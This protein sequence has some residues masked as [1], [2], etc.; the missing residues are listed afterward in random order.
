MSGFFFSRRSITRFVTASIMIGWMLPGGLRNCPAETTLKQQAGDGE[1]A[2]I[3]END[4]LRLTITPASGGRGASLIDK[5]TGKEL[6]RS[7]TSSQAPGGSGL[8][9]D[10]FW[11][12]EQIR[13]FEEMPYEATVKENSPSVVS[14]TLTRICRNLKVEKTVTLQ[15]GCRSIQVDY[16]ITNEGDQDYTGRFWVVNSVSPAAASRELFF[17]YPYGEFVSGGTDKKQ[18]T[19]ITYNPAEN[20]ATAAEKSNVYVID[21]AR[22]WGAVASEDKIGAVFQIEYPYFERFYSY[23]PPSGGGEAIPTFEW[24]YT[25]M[26]LP[27][28]AK[29]KAEAILHPEAL[30]PL[31]GYI[32]RTGWRLIPFAGLP[33]VDGVAEG[34][35]GSLIV[36]REGVKV[37][38]AGDRNRELQV[39]VSRYVSPT[40]KPEEQL[41]SRKMDL[42]PG[43][44]E[45]FTLPATLREKGTCV[46]RVTLKER[47]DGREIAFF[48]TPSVNET[49][50]FPYVMAPRETKDRLFSPPE[51][52]AVSFGTEGLDPCIEWA[53]PL[54]KPVKALVIFPAPAHREVAELARR[55]DIDL[56]AVAV[57]LPHVP[58]YDPWTAWWNS[59]PF[60]ILERSLAK[61]YDVIVIAGSL[62]WNTLP[63]NSRNT[64]LQKVKEGAGLIY[65]NPYVFNGTELE[66]LLKTP[67][68]KPDTDFLTSGV[69]SSAIPGLKEF[70]PFS[71]VCDTYPCGKGRIVRINYNVFPNG[72]VY[73]AIRC[74][75]P[76]VNDDSGYYFPYWEYYY[77]FVTKAILFAAQKEPKVLFA[78]ME[79]QRNQKRL[80]IKINNSGRKENVE[81]FLTVYN[82]LWEKLEERT[83]RL[84]LAP[85]LNET[86]L[87]VDPAKFRLAGDH[88][89]NVIVKKEG[90][91]ENWAT[92]CVN[93]T[94]PVR[95]AE[96]TMVKT[97]Y[98]K[99]DPILARIAVEHDGATE[100][101]RYSLHY[102]ISDV[103]RRVLVDK[104]KEF[105]A[106]EKTGGKTTVALEEK[107]DV[108]ALSTLCSLDVEL[109]DGKRIVDYARTHFTV[110]M[111]VEKDIIFT[112]WGPG[113]ANHWTQRVTLQHL[114]ELGFQ[115]ATGPN[116]N[117][118]A[119]EIPAIARGYLAAGLD[120][121]PMDLHRFG[122]GDL[123]GVVRTPC[124]TDPVYLEKM[125]H[126]VERGTREYGEYFPPAFFVG[127]ENSLGS[128]S[129]PHDFCQSPT[130]LEKFR[131]YLKGKY[132]S[133]EKLNGIWNTS[134][135][136]WDKVLPYTLAEAKEKNNFVP[137][138]E[139]RL[140]IFGVFAGAFENEKRFL[141][142]TDP[143]GR[144]AASGMGIPDVNNGFDWYLLSQQLDYIVSYGGPGVPEML[145]S[146]KRPGSFLGSWQGYR[147]SGDGIQSAVWQE[148]FM[149]FLNPGYWWQGLL[150]N[151]GDD[152]PSQFGRDYRK[153]I[154]E[155]KE[156]GIGKILVEA[157]WIPS[158]VA[159]LQSTP[160]LIA[161][162]VTGNSS[163]LQQGV[164]Q[165]NLGGWSDLV[166][167]LGFPP[168]DFLSGDQIKAGRLSPGKYPLFALPLSQALSNEEMDAI[169]SYVKQGGILIADSRPG[170]FLE[171]CCPRKTNPLDEVFGISSASQRIDQTDV[172]ISFS[173]D[174]G[175][176]VRLPVTPVET[177]LELK[178]GRA[179][180][181]AAVKRQTKTVNFGGLAVQ[182]KSDNAASTPAFIL[183]KYGKGY[184]LLLNCEF[185]NYS[186]LS[187]QGLNNRV[188]VEAMKAMLQKAGFESEVKADLP[189]GS[190][191]SRYRDGENEYYGLSRGLD[192]SRENN[193][194]RITLPKN[195]DIYEVRTHKYLGRS[196][197]ISTT[198]FPGEAKLFALCPYRRKTITLN[199]KSAAP[200]RIG[201]RIGLRDA[202]GKGCSGIVRLEVYSGGVLKEC[203]T[204]NLK[205]PAGG[206]QDQIPLGL[207]EPMGRWRLKVTD[208][209][210]GGAY[211]QKI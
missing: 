51:E 189:S 46:Y 49:S 99:G 111:P 178:G 26:K 83:V 155:L 44:T 124:L 50:S 149:Q 120:I 185:S 159:I 79:F 106:D 194:V 109:L 29:G 24:L 93:I 88:F 3:L 196:N 170:V 142:T 173:G 211:E 192:S 133:V 107:L 70:S 172:C 197:A 31:K 125:K 72:E 171:N 103:N 184:G 27:P 39:V 5:K 108:P 163:V 130:C 12:N 165:N 58:E 35:V 64:I 208:V 182:S 87:P 175:K 20:P 42:F 84:E 73:R 41:D 203:Y 128:Y 134:F 188:L 62:Y 75:T 154:R 7:M 186:V 166:R 104:R 116:V 13:G 168:P 19:R 10:R 66:T 151:A 54:D 52:T 112:V 140:F 9:L 167:N 162:T 28:L 15:E 81:F 40:G 147:A 34:I 164:F 206:Y 22:T 152:T 4:Y 174:E 89:L 61:D 144:L 148:A 36:D 86:A 21:P 56:T 100:S 94:N 65:V 210:T 59:N 102:R 74:L 114:R 181:S 91:V 14:L 23:Q 43:K 45:T 177:G 204:R 202:S 90:K 139:H 158:P 122:G 121:L 57:A 63:E 126:D 169:V 76:V 55:M 98:C 33:T 1:K 146:F 95:L 137:W 97:A 201:Y 187:K 123:K 18:I 199:V 25:P 119:P 118:T 6:I 195:R 156:S 85:G 136:A 193:A 200:G 110:R 198:L 127:D 105:S 78:G 161:A 183:N 11:G 176:P 32:F 191:L 143:E 71:K 138:A 150:L 30:D 53:K 82:R 67:P 38:L 16:R 129:S 47:K 17:F 190:Q 145:R 153:I 80:V 8:F 48:E 141:T 96:V 117:Q 132:Q 209:I 92:A 179:L 207:N 160:S 115:W 2:Y 205:V 37:G 180:G 101:G 135:A 68:I 113:D 157:E 60:K 69:P 77:S 131:A